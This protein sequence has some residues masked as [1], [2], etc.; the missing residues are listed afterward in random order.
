[1]LRV[2]LSLAIL[3]LPVTSAMAEDY[4]DQETGKVVVYKNG[5]PMFVY[6]EDA[7][8]ILERMVNAFNSNTESTATSSVFFQK[9][10]RDVNSPAEK[11][12]HIKDGSY[13]SARLNPP[14]ELYEDAVVLDEI[15]VPFTNNPDENPIGLLMAKLKNG[16]VRAYQV[17]NKELLNIYCL[18]KAEKYLPEHYKSFA[19]KYSDPKYQEMGIECTYTP[20]K[21]D[22]DEH[23]ES[24]KH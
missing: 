10:T 24:G 3:T 15:I 21:D 23:K 14:E 6:E 11:W 17:D 12:D 5:Q 20:H 9:I 4:T 16:E 7:P 19:E 22:D 1:M 2:I 8:I 13:F 18:D